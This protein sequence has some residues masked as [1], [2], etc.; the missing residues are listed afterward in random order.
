MKTHNNKEED[1]R[2]ESYQ[3]RYKRYVNILNDIYLKP[4]LMGKEIAK[5][6]DVTTGYISQIKRKF[7]QL[8]YPPKVKDGKLVCYLCENPERLGFHH[9]VR[10]GE[11]IALICFNCNA[12]VKQ[13]SDFGIVRGENKLKGWSKEKEMDYKT[14]E[15]IKDY[16]LKGLYEI[17]LNDMKPIKKLTEKE[18]DIIKKIESLLEVV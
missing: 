8:K 12:Q 11:Q 10:T 7:S 1:R 4:N 16:Y 3:E 5:K 17:M 9:T 2:Y 6:Y 15:F 18:I 13:N 14:A